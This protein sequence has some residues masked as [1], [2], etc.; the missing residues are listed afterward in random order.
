[1]NIKIWRSALVWATALAMAS[2][3]HSS[4]DAHDHDHEGEGKQTHENEKAHD[5]E[6]V[7]ELSA[8]LGKMSGIEVQT[9]TDSTFSEAVTAAGR[10]VAPEASQGVVTAKTSGVVSFSAPSLSVGSP[11]SAG[12]TLFTISAKGLEQS[13]GLTESTAASLEQAEKNYRRAE[14]L[15]K[16]KLVTRAEYEQ[17]KAEYDKALAAKRG[18]AVRA[19]SGSVAASSPTSGV[20]TELSVKPGQFVAQ[21]ERLA[22]VSQNRRLMLRVA[23]SERQ[24]AAMPDISD[25]VVVIPALGK[26]AYRLSDYNLRVVSS[27]ST[28]AANGHYIPVMLEFDNPGLLRDGNVAEVTLRGGVRTGVMS[29]PRAALVEEMGLSYIFVEVHE[30]AFRRV[31]VEMGASDGERVEI[32]GDVKPGDKVAVSGVGAIRRAENGNVVPAGHSH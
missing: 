22:S 13:S 32:H 10:V 4:S 30:N 2:C 20:I 14:R 16:E 9:V 5:H 18:A 25:A 3:G 6:G 15:V 21:G 17:A 28:A 7:I 11:V 26:R 24:A 8:D 31:R 27:P 12:Q 19:A 23:L 29:V 1:M